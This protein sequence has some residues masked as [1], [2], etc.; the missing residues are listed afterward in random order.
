MV[1]CH[2]GVILV[3]KL[4]VLIIIVVV[5]VVVVVITVQSHQHVIFVVHKGR[6]GRSHTFQ[7]TQGILDFVVGNVQYLTS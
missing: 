2:H 4:V 6:N 1:S 7:N 5:V 3:K